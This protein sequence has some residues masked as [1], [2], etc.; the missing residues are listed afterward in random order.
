MIG[1]FATGKSTFIC[2]MKHQNLPTPVVKACPLRY[3]RYL[4]LGGQTIGEN[5]ANPSFDKDAMIEAI[6]GAPREELEQ[7]AS[8]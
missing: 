7:A 2:R 5:I 3:L 8:Y 1:L 4:M 6:N